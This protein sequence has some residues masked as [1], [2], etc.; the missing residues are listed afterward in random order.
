MHFTQVS[1]VRDDG[2]YEA[3]C[4]EGHHFFTLCQNMKWELLFDSGALALRD[5]YYRE[6]VA[7]V[8][9]ALEDFYAF[10]VRIV[11]RAHNVSPETIVKFSKSTRLSERR[12][13]AMHLA[14]TLETGEPYTGDDDKRRKFRNDVIHDG[15]WPTADE[16]REYARYVY[17]LIQQLAESIAVAHPDAESAE[18][19]APLARAHARARE[20]AKKKSDVRYV[21][22]GV[23]TLL[24]YTFS[25]K[26]RPFQEAW[27]DWVSLNLW[28]YGKQSDVDEGNP[29]GLATSVE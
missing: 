8:T 24:K 20:Q 15:Y 17:D 27:S 26:P 4:P 1:D 14:Y 2:A 11:L 3:V 13:G 9:A 10:Y 23:L 21:T 18:Q 29:H 12:L 5:G 7:S 19:I 6:A 16:A 28:D 22:L 25:N